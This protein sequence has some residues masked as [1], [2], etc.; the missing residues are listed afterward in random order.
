MLSVHFINRKW[1]NAST[2]SEFQLK[3]FKKLQIF[4]IF[5]P[6][7]WSQI[8]LGYHPVAQYANASCNWMLFGVTFSL[9][10]WKTYHF[11]RKLTKYQHQKF[12]L[13]AHS[14]STK[15]IANCCS[16]QAAPKFRKKDS[17]EEKRNVVRVH[18]YLAFIRHHLLHPVETCC[19]YCG[20][21]IYSACYGH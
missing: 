21:S 19:V 1:S 18:V 9:I 17:F 14:E 20:R 2:L 13:I 3:L 5:H 10:C 8:F 15:Y 12:K 16:A 4:Q 7:Y 11:S 6:L